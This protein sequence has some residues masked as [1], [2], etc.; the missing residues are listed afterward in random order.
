MPHRPHGPILIV[1]DRRSRA[2]PAAR[3]HRA[4]RRHLLRLLRLL[5]LVVELLL[6][7]GLLLGVPA[8]LIGV[9]LLA[10][11][12]FLGGSL[13]IHLQARQALQAVELVALGACQGCRKPL[14]ESKRGKRYCSNS[15]RARAS[16]RRASETLASTS[17]IGWQRAFETSRRENDALVLANSLLQEKLAALAAR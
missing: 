4:A 1:R 6:P 2:A 11:G 12:L 13:L 15:C 5:L 8:A 7:P 3:R 14:P 9:V 17:I 10:V 16:E